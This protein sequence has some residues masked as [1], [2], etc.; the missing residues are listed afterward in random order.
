MANLIALVLVCILCIFA[1]S[2]DASLAVTPIDTLDRVFPDQPPK[3]AAG[4]ETHV[5]RGAHASFQFAVQSD[6]PGSCELAVGPLTHAD[7]TVLNAPHATYHLLAVHVEGNSQGTAA[8]HPYP[9]KPPDDW[10]PFLTR[11]APFDVAEVLEPTDLFD[12]E[13]GRT[14]AVV[15]DVEIPLDAKPGRYEGTLRCEIGGESFTAPLSAVVHST[16]FDGYALDV[17]NWLFIEPRN[18]T[19]GE[20]PE[21]WSEAHWDLI[22]SAGRLL[23]GYGQNTISTPHIHTVD[24]FPALI[25]TRV[26][27]DG[28]YSFDFARFDRWMELFLELGYERI[29]GRHVISRAGHMPHRIMGTPADGGE[30]A[31]LFEG[32]IKVAGE[33]EQRYL[34]YLA[35]FFDALHAHLTE[36]G[37][38]DRYMQHVADEPVPDYEDIYRRY[39]AVFVEHLP[40]VP[41]L[42]ADWSTPEMFSPLMA[43]QVMYIDTLAHSQA[44]AAER[45]AAG[46]T[47][48]MYN[49]G[50]PYPPRP[51]RWLDLPLTN[52]RLYPWLG[53]R[54]NASGYLFWGAN[55]FRGADPYTRSVGPCGEGKGYPGHN[56]GDNWLFYPAPNG[57]Y[58][59]IRMVAFRD[60]MVDHALLTQLAKIDPEAARS[61]TDR[62]VR[63]LVDYSQRPADYHRARAM[64]LEALDGG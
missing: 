57:L 22:E 6:E 43:I 46:L 50:K 47:T 36:K 59:S 35:S 8:T 58:A 60:G 10:M 23:H 13:A 32:G 2:V 61:I 29:E 63:S 7:G 41:N 33:E 25:E 37:W 5:P 27:A 31:L 20:R 19:G 62:I 26:N 4:R 53:V 45:E 18:L 40:G 14:H 39:H 54:Y 52:S 16:T 15:V 42:D 9:A 21:F 56:P 44:L 3:D 48:W 11:E 64:L 1:S 30:P 28:S 34:E 12:A 38:L 49:F 51:N 55:V 24:D 17:T